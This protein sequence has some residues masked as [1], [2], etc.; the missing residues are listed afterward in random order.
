M[1]GEKKKESAR[2]GPAGFV[3]GRPGHPLGRSSSWPRRHSPPSRPAAAIC[4]RAAGNGSFTAATVP[5]RKLNSAEGATK[6]EPKRR[7][8]RLSAKPAPA[9]EETK[10]KKAAGKNKSSD[11]R[12]NK[13]EKGSKG[14][15]G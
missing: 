5:E 12:A 3:R 10:P 6:E 9:K 7:S 15:T 1:T 4:S 2:S 11:K 14:K 8:L 13:R